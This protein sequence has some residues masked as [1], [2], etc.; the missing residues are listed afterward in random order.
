MSL[1]AVSLQGKLAVVS[2]SDTGVGQR[3]PLGLA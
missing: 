2:A 3:L 1:D